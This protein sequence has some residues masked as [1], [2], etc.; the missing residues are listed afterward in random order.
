V[1]IGQLGNSAAA[2]A[3]TTADDD[4]IVI[5]GLSK[6]FKSRRDVC[7]ALTG[8]SFRTRR[9]S[10]TALI[11]PSGCGKSTILRILA[12]LEH[13]SGGTVLAHGRAPALVR[14]E[15]RLGIAFQEP[16]LL[17]WR[18]VRSNLELA[19]EVTGLPIPKSA[20]DDLIG[21]VGL[22]GF[23]RARPAELSGG[24]RQRVAIARALITSP[25][26]LLLDEPFGALDEMTRRRLNLEL[27]RIWSERVTTTLLVTHSIEE[28]VFLSDTVLVM[29]PRP[30][31]IKS[32]VDVGF[33]RPRRAD[34]L[35]DPAFHAKADLVSELLSAAG[36]EGC[37]ENR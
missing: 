8:V 28:A 25:E 37:D 6:T 16:A 33:A 35:H 7:V 20:C 30:G 19:L 18:T 27:L 32:I 17:P 29:T 34:L 14:K 23:E 9:G 2:S 12:D 11:G 4:G 3:A 24:M 36:D 10:F 26:V 1:D 5:E 13:P 31:R 22:Q 21:L 15:R